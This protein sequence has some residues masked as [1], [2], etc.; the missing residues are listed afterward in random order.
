MPNEVVPNLFLKRTI[1][2]LWYTVSDRG[3]KM[4]RNLR[5]IGNSLGLLLPKQ[6]LDDMN[7]EEGDGVEIIYNADKKEIILRNKKIPNATESAIRE[8]IEK[9]LKE[10]GIG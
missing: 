4:E 9:I 7:L 8:M 5:K 3:E 6:M 2:F 10:K 1:I